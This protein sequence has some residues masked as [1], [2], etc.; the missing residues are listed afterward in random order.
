MQQRSRVT[1][2]LIALVTIAAIAALTLGACANSG[3]ASASG[4]SSSGRVDQEQSLLEFARCVRENGIPNYEDPTV[5]EDGNVQF[6]P[7]S[8][9]DPDVMREAMGACEDKLG[10]LTMGGG[11]NGDDSEVQDAFVR[12]AECMRDE[13][14]E[15]FPDPDFS[16]EGMLPFD[17]ELFHRNDPV[18]QEAFAACEDL[19]AGIAPGGGMP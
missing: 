1:L 12:F 6:R 4:S 5:D 17:P 10:G 2:R 7:P 13:G 15:D 8:G 9:V 19:L 11:A 18:Y 3:D 16:R 14:I